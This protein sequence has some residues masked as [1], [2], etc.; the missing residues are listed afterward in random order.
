MSVKKDGGVKVI[1]DIP[2]NI[3]VESDVCK[4]QRL[5][6]KSFGEHFP[7]SG[8][9]TAPSSPRPGYG[10]IMAV[11][12]PSSGPAAVEQV[13]VAQPSAADPWPGPKEPVVLLT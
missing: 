11:A 1:I 9:H 8:P 6:S 3:G 10:L 5:A 2:Q 7:P 13:P 4:S 12:G